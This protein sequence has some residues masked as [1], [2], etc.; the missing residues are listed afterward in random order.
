MG[1][2]ETAPRE[3]VDGLYAHLEQELDAADYFFPESKAAPMR[4][5]LRNLLSRT[6]LTDQDVRMMRG[7]IRA[8]AEKRRRKE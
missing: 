4:E 7:V 3:A 1:K 6:P 8:L 2:T 5:S